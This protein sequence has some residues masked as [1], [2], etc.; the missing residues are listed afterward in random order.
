MDDADRAGDILDRAMATYKNSSLQ[1]RA[2]SIG[3]CR[4]CGGVIEAGRLRAM[5]F[6]VRC[7]A[8]QTE[9]ETQR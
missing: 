2:R 7:I 8:C 5:P 1:P 4:D 3:R 9:A 6:A